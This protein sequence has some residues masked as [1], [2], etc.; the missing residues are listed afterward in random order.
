MCRQEQ[1]CHCAIGGHCG[2]DMEDYAPAHTHRVKV[3]G[4]GT[5]KG[6]D[7]M[8]VIV[9]H[10]VLVVLERD[11]GEGNGPTLRGLLLVSRTSK[12]TG[13]PTWQAAATSQSHGCPSTSTS[14][15]DERLSEGASLPPTSLLWAR[16]LG[17]HGSD[18]IL[19]S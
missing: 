17:T 14:A 9:V 1:H 16:A 6:D 3:E 8:Q 18:L 11:H 15:R 13:S 7:I 5:H 10:T 19:F 2:L 12:R 4:T